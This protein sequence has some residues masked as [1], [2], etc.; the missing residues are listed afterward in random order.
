MSPD[1]RKALDTNISSAQTSVRNASADE[2]EKMKASKQIKDIKIALDKIEKEKEMPQLV[3]EFKDGIQDTQ[4]IINEYADEKD[5]TINNDQLSKLKAEGEKAITD[6]D[7]S[8][9]VRINEQ[10]NELR[11]K[12]VYSNPATWVHQFN[13]LIAGNPTFINEKEA[14]YYIEKGKRAIQLGDT[15]EIKR[16][17]HNLLLLLPS[18]VQETIKDNLSGITR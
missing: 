12:A 1:E 7:K 4:S 2:D 16:C 5:K 6:S 10:I 11:S 15:D 3:K 18:D 14:K 9:L 17:V 13:K 8:L